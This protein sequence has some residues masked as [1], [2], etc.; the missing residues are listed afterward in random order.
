MFVQDCMTS[1]PRAIEPDATLHD[2]LKL[3]GALKVRHLP[4]VDGSQLVGIVTWT[5]LMG[6]VPSSGKRRRPPNG[7]GLLHNAQVKD[8]MTKDP[9]TISP[10]APGSRSP[11]CVSTPA[12]RTPDPHGDQEGRACP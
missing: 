3:M 11:I 5:D 6:I 2:A 9:L 4:V 12:R 10:D 1:D 7:S 8:V